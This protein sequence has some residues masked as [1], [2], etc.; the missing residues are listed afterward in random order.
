MNAPQK[1]MPPSGARKVFSGVMWSV[2]QWQQKMY[3]GSFETFE[4]VERADAATAFVIADN[5]ILLQEQEQ[6]DREHPFLSFPGG[7]ID[8]GETPAQAIVREVLEET[9]YKGDAPELWN[10][11][12]P[13]RKMSWAVY[14]Y[15]IRNA[16]K[17]AEPLAQKGERFIHEWVT[18]DDLF[19]VIHRDHFRDRGLKIELLDIGHSPKKK[20]EFRNL[21]FRGSSS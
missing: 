9:G 10:V 5:A 19:R 20:E 8:P 1:P 11:D 2:W 14:Y 15:I 12:V 6:P 17:V 16:Q 7:R 21:L 13:S 3:D 4:M 18:F